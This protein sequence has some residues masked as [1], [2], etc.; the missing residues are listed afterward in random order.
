MGGM[1][2]RWVSAGVAVL[3]AVVMGLFTYVIATARIPAAMVG[4]SFAVSNY[5]FF[6][7]PLGLF[8]VGLSAL[9]AQRRMHGALRLVGA[10][11]AAVCL[12][13]VVAA[14]FPLVASWRTA[15]R[16]DA[17]L[18]VL[19]YLTDGSNRGR[20]VDS[21]STIYNTIDGTPLLLDAKVPM[22]GPSGPR[23]A[24]VW[25]HGGGWAH[26]DRGEAPKWHKWLNDKGYAVFSIEYRMSPPPRWDQA[27]AD[28]KCA[29]GWVKQHALEYTIDPE[30]V[31][32]AGGS[33]GGNL[34]LMAAYAEPIAPSCA[35]TDTS[36][37]AVAAFYPPTDLAAGWRNPRLLPD[38]RDLVEDYTGGT[39]DRAPSHYAAAS[40]INYVR[41]GLPPTLV[42]HGTRDHVVPYGE[43]VA[44]IDRLD[45]AGV[46]NQLLPIPYG[47][48]AYDFTWGDWGTQ[49]SRRVFADFLDEHFPAR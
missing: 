6:L 28:V 47:E 38:I 41:P 8:G 43:S 5:G 14:G 18:S 13:G 4:L 29:I 17:K 3:V 33:A 25:V 31:M 24:V 37:R 32:V 27:P 19:D 11:T 22:G 12:V 15:D 49:T 42:M 7:I 36:V 20:P 10:V 26:G 44:F 2:V 30:R 40:P 39:P 48:H 35:V 21:L 34:A 46:P 1:V 16:Y 45:D 9:L 23:P